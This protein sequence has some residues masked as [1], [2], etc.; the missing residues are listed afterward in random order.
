MFS[1]FEIVL[2]AF[3]AFIFVYAVVDRICR[4]V[5]HRHISDS[6]GKNPACAEMIKKSIEEDLD[7]YIL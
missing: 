7:K 3:V 4:C 1:T 2:F 6:I 5:E